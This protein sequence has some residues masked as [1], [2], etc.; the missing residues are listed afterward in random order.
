MPSK[1]TEPEVPFIKGR[2]HKLVRMGMLIAPGLRKV[3]TRVKPYAEAW[4][5]SNIE[6]VKNGGQ[7]WVVLGDSMSQGVG[8]SAHNKGWVGQAADMLRAKG[9]EYQIINL[10]SSGAH[11][12]DVI[13]VQLAALRTLHIKPSLITVLVGSNDLLRSSLRKRLLTNLEILLDKLPE[14]TIIGDVFNGPQTPKFIKYLLVS[15]AASNLLAD[16]A[17]RQKLVVVHINQAFQPPWHEKLA[18]DHFHPND[19]GYKAIAQAFVET[20]LAR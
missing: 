6:S 1:N 16:R 11:I 7:I 3:Q 13:K 8:A 12:E 18:T 19:Q 20:I 9:H 17:D 15:K 5:K 2:R 14:G 4:H 10:S